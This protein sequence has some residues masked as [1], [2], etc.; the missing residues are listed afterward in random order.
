MFTVGLYSSVQLR[1]HLLQR[2]DA[3]LTAYSGELAKSTIAQ[4]K[5]NSGNPYIAS[6][7]PTNVYAVR[8]VGA[9]TRDIFPAR[10]GRPDFENL[11]LSRATVKQHG[12]KP[13]TINGESPGD[14]QWRVIEGVDPGTGYVY[15]VAVSLRP[16]E[17]VIRQM[18]VVTIIV[19]SITLLVAV[20]MGLVGIRRALRPLADIEDTAAAI[21]GGDLSRRVPNPGSRDE[22]ESLA[23][24]LN[25]MLTQL[26]NLIEVK[27]RSEESMRRF[28]ADASHELR[29]PLATVRG[30]S[31]LYRQGAMPNEEAVTAGFRRIEEEANRMSR[32]VE[33]LLLLSRLEAEQRASTSD[34]SSS[35][36]SSSVRDVDLTVVA[37]DTGADAGARAKT[38]EEK[39]RFRVSGLDG[40]L[41]PVLVRGDEQRLRQVVTNLVTNAVR[42][43]PAG[44][45]I[46][47]KVGARDEWA[48]LQVIDHGPGIPA[49]IRARVFDR[50]YRADVAR[51]RAEGSTG[52]GLSIVAAIVSGHNGK[53]RVMETPGGG[54]TFEIRLPLVANCPADDLRD[55]DL[56][57]DELIDF[58]SGD[59]APTPQSAN[60]PVEA[61]GEATVR[62]AGRDS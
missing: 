53:V 38:D 24:S 41:R 49:D 23:F 21:A 54:A 9:K 18:Q 58:E 28:V 60:T 51:N 16:M 3:E 44:T 27:D 30:Y 5:L 32:M 61:D 48:V 59:P 36:A 11:A 12:G 45:P 2:E 4:E 46:E 56:S 1:A 35:T 42:Y 29:T 19:S 40:Q 55:D 47:L 14:P 37:A 10:D 57:E 25:T 13:Y 39:L 52:L 31:E 20:G 15:A 7:I 50:F 22:I 43:T 34:H 33:D 8:I 6:N 62:D 26:E 17:N